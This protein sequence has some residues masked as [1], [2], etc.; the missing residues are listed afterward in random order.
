[1]KFLYLWPLA[2]LVLIPIIIIMYLLKQKAVDHPFS[3]LFLWKEMY[4][5]MQANTPWE[6]LK[7]N[8]L[9]YLQIATVLILIFALMSPYIKSETT[10]AGHV[11]LVLDTSG[12][13]N[14][15]YDDGHTR[16]E[17]A[18][19]E[20]IDYVDKLPGDTSISIITSDKEA[21][22]V[23]TDSVDKSLAKRRLN[24]IEATNYMGDCSFGM[25]MAESMIAQWESAEVVY[26]T[27]TYVSCKTTGGYIVDVY[28]EQDNAVVEYVGHGTDSEGMLTVLAKVSN[29]GSKELKT[30]INLYGDDEMLAVKEVTI[31]SGDSEIV[32][33]EN[34][35]FDGKVIYAELHDVKDALTLDNGCYDVI[36]EASECNVLL[37]T[38]QN[39]YLEKAMALMDGVKVTKSNDIDGFK[40][41]LSQ[42][43]DLYVFDGMVPAELPKNG[44]MLFINCECPELYTVADTLEGIL[45]KVKDSK[46]TKYLEDYSFGASKVKAMEV[47]GWADSFLT[48]GNFSAGFIGTYGTQQVC[49]L[50]MDF[51]DTELPLKSEFPILIYNIMNECVST[52]MLSASVV[53]AG[54]AIKVSGKIDGAK[55]VIERPDGKNEELVG[56]IVNYTGTNETGVY[57]VEQNAD[58]EKLSE[59][60]AVNFPKNESFIQN[61]PGGSLEAGTSVVQATVNSSLNLRNVII[62]LALILLCIEWIVYIRR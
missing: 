46:V 59:V 28:S 8:L 15:K 51:H 33:F 5:N 55:P 20:A 3:S 34:L 48:A 45:L 16:M 1:M 10:S 19:S 37:M 4:K 44:S 61:T 18:V 52:G 9:M 40:D 50:G 53:N 60:F 42:E 58:G 7:K 54:S 47:P 43:Y 24:A 62:I 17:V 25:E 26:F 56:T 22:L 23:L 32:Y 49:V 27:D 38:E 57:E 12:S 2:L 41:F 36:T 11:V 29:F 13:M 21:V 14:T 6:K 39:L 31:P 30:D 35:A